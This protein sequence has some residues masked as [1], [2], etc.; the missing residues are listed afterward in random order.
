M[1]NDMKIEQHYMKKG[2]KFEK[3]PKNWIEFAKL[4]KMEQNLPN[5]TKIESEPQNYGSIGQNL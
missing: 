4:F 2:K 1:Q 3:L 5:Y